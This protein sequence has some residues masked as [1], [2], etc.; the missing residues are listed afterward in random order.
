MDPIAAPGCCAVVATSANLG[1][2]GCRFVGDCE[3]EVVGDEV[4]LTGRRVS[5]AMHVARLVASVLLLPALAATFFGFIA[6]GTGATAG[7][8]VLIISA[9]IFLGGVGVL[10][11]TD[12]WSPRHAKPE[13]VKWKAGSVAKHKRI[14]DSTSGV[15]FVL[16]TLLIR[17]ADGKCVSRASVPIGADGRMQ[18]LFLRSAPGAHDSLERVLLTSS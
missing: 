3:L 15:G 4:Q 12:I 1:L 17:A 9:L 13:T 16:P 8:L 18:R 14:S 7:L 2:G 11:A 10:V 5:S 6:Y